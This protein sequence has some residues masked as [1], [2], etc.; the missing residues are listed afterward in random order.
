MKPFSPFR[1]AP[2]KRYN[3]ARYGSESPERLI[4][5]AAWLSWRFPQAL[6]KGAITLLLAAGLALGAPGCGDSA[7]PTYDDTDGVAEDCTSDEFVCEDEATLRICDDNY[8]WKSV[9]CDAY[10]TGKGYEYSNGCDEE[11]TDNPCTCYEELAGV[12]DD[13]TECYPDQVYCKD[14]KTLTICNDNNQWEA[15]SCDSYCFNSPNFGPGYFSIRCDAENLDDP[16]VCEY[17]TISGDPMDCEPGDFYCLDDT[18]LSFCTPDNHWHSVSCDAHC[19]GKGYEHSNGCDSENTDNPCLCEY[20]WEG[21][22]EP[23]CHPDEIYCAD[24]NTLK[25]C[26]DDYYWESISCNERCANDPDFGPDYYS[27]G[28]EAENADNPCLCEYGIIDGDPVECTPAD[29][30]CQDAE[31]ALWCGDYYWETIGCEVWCAGQEPGSASQGCS[32]DDEG[33]T[34]PCACAA[35]E[36]SSTRKK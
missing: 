6:V 28:C 2:V 18:T 17:D 8:Q 15:V 25:V 14:T 7:D 33:A 1:L 26:N 31:T 21:G 23:E 5:F 29:S 16:C 10:C 35:P 19:T 30:T 24:Q 27:A 36:D 9:S 34:A 3:K 22:L 12:P 13:W 11:N 32:A 4:G 20:G